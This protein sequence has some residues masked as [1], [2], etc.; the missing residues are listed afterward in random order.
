MEQGFRLMFGAN[1]GGAVWFVFLPCP[2]FKRY[3]MCHCLPVAA[4]PAFIYG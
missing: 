4:I 2:V 1:K 3:G